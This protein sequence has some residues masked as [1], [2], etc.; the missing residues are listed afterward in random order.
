MGLKVSSIAGSLLYNAQLV[1]RLSSIQEAWV[2][3]PEMNAPVSPV[4]GE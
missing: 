3:A 4:L 1:E 2:Q